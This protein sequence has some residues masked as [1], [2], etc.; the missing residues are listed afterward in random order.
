MCAFRCRV[1]ALAAL[2]MLGATPLAAQTFTEALAAAR[3]TDAQYAAALSTALTRRVQA[4]ESST[5]FY[6]SGSV[7]YQPSALGSGRL[8]R[9]LTLSQPLLSADR[10]LAL[11]QVDPFE[12]QA[13][14]EAHLAD[15][16]LKRRL[17]KAMADIVRFAEVLRATAVQ[18]EGLQTQLQRA[19]RMHQLGQGTITEISDFEV[20]VAVSQANAIAQ[21]NAM[22]AAERSFTLLTGIRS[23]AGAIS[24]DDA[25]SAVMPDGEAGFVATVRERAASVQVAREAVRLQE[26]AARRARAVYL[27]TL[28]ATA[29]H[30]RTSGAATVN[31][32]RVGLSLNVTLDSATLMNDRRAAIELAR[33]RNV[34][35]YQQDFAASEAVR[36]LRAAEAYASEVSIRERA[37]V[38]A[39]LALQGNLKSY[40]GGVKSNIDVVTSYQNVADAEVAL[41]N[42]RLSRTET[43]LGIALLLPASEAPALVEPPVAPLIPVFRQQDARLDSEAALSS[44]AK[45]GFGRIEPLVPRAAAAGP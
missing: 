23:G 34:L 2:A 10:Y 29:T 25:A 44:D 20:R 11:R 42:A 37:L 15:A 41:V 13:T 19:R 30:S 12:K 6:P 32:F 38:A 31:D 18:V 26:I 36:L 5:A 45:S 39:K 24:V 1:A 8:T 22:E 33:V 27:P 16:D 14:A 7:G 35:R 43:L 3:K 4:A 9:S 40:E 17:F 21:R 28:D